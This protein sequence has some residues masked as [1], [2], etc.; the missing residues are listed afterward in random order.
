MEALR[1]IGFEEDR[2]AS[3]IMACQGMFKYQ[4]DTD[5]DLKFIHVFPKARHPAP[6]PSSRPRAERLPPSSVL[7]L[8]AIPSMPR[9]RAVTVD[10][11]GAHL[12]LHL[13]E[14]SLHH[15]KPYP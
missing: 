15:L 13:C 11:T 1:G 6:H 12:H 5:K 10:S 4:H 8:P 14:Y 9:V 7:G 2:G 3:A